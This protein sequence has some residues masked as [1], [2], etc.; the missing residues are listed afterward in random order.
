MRRSLL[1]VVA[2]CLAVAA[3]V[4]ASALATSGTSTRRA[5]SPPPTT[6]GAV[7]ADR[8]AKRLARQDAIAKRLG[9]TGAELRAAQA[10]AFGAALRRAVAAG[11]ITEAQRG[12]LAACRTTPLTCDRTNLPVRPRR[13]LRGQREQMTADVAKALGVDVARLRAARRAVRPAGARKH[14]RGHERAH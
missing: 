13:V 6:R 4:S 10:E 5:A 2:C 14:R 9:K 7:R 1:T 3:V 8:Q 12:A 11:T